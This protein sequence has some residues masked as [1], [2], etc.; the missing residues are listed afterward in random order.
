MRT[1][2]LVFLA[3]I[4]TVGMMSGCAS[5]KQARKAVPSGFLKP[6]EYAL[7]KRTKGDN[8]QLMYVNFDADW[9]KYKNVMIEPVTIWRVPGT[10]LETLS[11]EDLNMIGA[12]VYNALRDELSK[13]YT[14][15]DKPGPATLKMRP[16]ITEADKSVVA[17]DMF[18]TVFPVGLA[19]SEAKEL[20]TG[21]GTF[22]GQA[23]A[24]SEIRDAQTG[25]L[26]AAGVMARVGQKAVNTSKMSSWGDVKSAAE[27]WAKRLRINL[28]KARKGELQ[29]ELAQ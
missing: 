7:M 22:V 23:A 9:K 15:V 2:F 17:L 4:V 11:K 14:I 25:E 19:A 29:A 3:G 5:T 6:D 27:A 13:D 1:T 18:T 8:A 24:E 12:F 10:K 16:A 28:E 26:L 20:A 21:T